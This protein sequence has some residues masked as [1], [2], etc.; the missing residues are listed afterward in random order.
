MSRFFCLQM[1]R[2]SSARRQ[3]GCGCLL[4][5][6]LQRASPR[7]AWFPRGVGNLPVPRVRGREVLGTGFSRRR[8]VAALSFQARVRA[9]GEDDGR[10]RLEGFVV[11]SPAWGG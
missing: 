5:V 10:G 4:V 1:A 3:D 8:V 6:L 7:A 9:E 11:V 2:G